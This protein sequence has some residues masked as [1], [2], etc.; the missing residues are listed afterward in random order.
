MRAPRNGQTIQTAPKLLLIVR[1]AGA[2]T[3]VVERAN[4]DL[5]EQSTPRT[6]CKTAEIS[7]R[8]RDVLHGVGKA[9]TDFDLVQKSRRKNAG[10]V[11]RDDVLAAAEALRQQITQDARRRFRA[12]LA[13]V[14]VVGAGDCRQFS[15]G[16]SVIDPAQSEIV[17]G[18]YLRD[19]RQ[20]HGAICSAAGL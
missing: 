9:V 14:I 20:Q 2:V 7:A 18:R 6:K 13:I 19:G 3:D 17:I 12:A 11:N 10:L 1:R 15:I 5:T 8:Q 16:E 4:L